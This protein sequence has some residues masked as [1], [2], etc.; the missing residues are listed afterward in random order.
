MFAMRG[1]SVQDVKHSSAP[2]STTGKYVV[3]GKKLEDLQKDL[4]GGGFVVG[5][6][7]TVRLS[8]KVRQR[9]TKRGRKNISQSP[10]EIYTFPPISITLRFISSAVTSMTTGA[11]TVGD[12]F[13]AILCIGRVVNSSVTAVA[14]S[15]RIKR[16]AVYPPVDAT[17][18]DATLVWF[19]GLD[20][21]EPDL[22]KT[23]TRAGGVSTPMGKVFVPPT[24]TVAGMWY[25]NVYTPQTE[26]VFAL[27]VTAGDF[28]I[29][30]DLDFTLSG[31][32]V[33]SLLSIGV[34]TAAVG[35]PYRLPL[36]RVNGS[37]QLYQVVNFPTTI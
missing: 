26:L 5:K 6:P 7:I 11:I 14:T 30:V 15:F 28:V 24:N 12:I 3:V 23:E 34:A 25:K 20:D 37:A 9:L 8:K 10:R 29:D 2:A 17:Y 16:V 33:G 36:N 13:G 18:N 1:S 35:N 32:P 21:R 19:T 4:K 22:Q 27:A 31:G